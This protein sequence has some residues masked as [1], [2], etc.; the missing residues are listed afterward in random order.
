MKEIKIVWGMAMGVLCAYFQEV[1]VP[2][3]VLCIVMLLDYA[4]G[5]C[6]AIMS[7]TLDS[8]TGLLGILKKVGY[9]C[10][11]AVGSVIDFLLSTGCQR[12]GIESPFDMAFA[13]VVIFWIIINE[14]IS[15]LENLEACGVKLPDFVVKTLKRANEKMEEE[16]KK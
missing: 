13:L 2:L 9:L 15:V 11:V 10:V 7:G 6:K 8:R 1:M 4:T 12:I 16:D 3:S 5:V 14:C